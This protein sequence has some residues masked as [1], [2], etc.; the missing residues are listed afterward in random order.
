MATR[1][2]V[3]EWAQK[4]VGLE[5]ARAMISTKPLE[6]KRRM[7]KT[8]CLHHLLDHEFETLHASFEIERKALGR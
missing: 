1:A 7:S 5:A 8:A 6:E 4:N 2:E 3:L